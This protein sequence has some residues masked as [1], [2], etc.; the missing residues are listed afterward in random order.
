M[1]PRCQVQPRPRCIGI[2]D[3]DDELRQEASCDVA[4]LFASQGACKA[5]TAIALLQV[6]SDPLL[7][8]GREAHG[9]TGARQDLQRASELGLRW[10]RL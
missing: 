6:L 4:H 3:E 2:V 10:R 9:S 1:H 8:Q 7:Q 5:A